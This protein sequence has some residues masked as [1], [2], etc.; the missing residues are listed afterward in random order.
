MDTLGRGCTGLQ[1]PL[2]HR[3]HSPHTAHGKPARTSHEMFS[4]RHFILKVEQQVR[5]AGHSL[6]LFFARSRLVGCLVCEF[7]FGIGKRSKRL[8]NTLNFFGQIGMVRKDHKETEVTEK[9]R[10]QLV[11][12]EAT[13]FG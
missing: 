1:D 10:D 5:I 8:E 6:H 11:R 4:L 13:L 2:D 9:R 12:L 3:V 7:Q